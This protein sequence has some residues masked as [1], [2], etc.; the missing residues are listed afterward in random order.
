M[1]DVMPTLHFVLLGAFLLVTMLLLAT[2]SGGLNRAADVELY[3]RDIRAHSL[4]IAPTIFVSVMTL[5]TVGALIVDLGIHPLIPA[6]YLVGGVLWM[7]AS[8]LTAAVVVTQHG[9]IVHGRDARHRVAWRQVVDY[10][11]FG[12]DR[13]Q[14][15]VLF[16]VDRKGSRCR[17]EIVVPMKCR[18][19]FGHILSRYVD[20]RLQP[21]AEETYG[22]P[23]LDR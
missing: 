14:G 16:Y 21:L 22:D 11:Q 19:Q 12:G 4:P 10:F 2:S 8:V 3:W 5:L 1:L 13:R 15:Y 17:V 20:T 9:V 7:M 6:G 18:E 23:R